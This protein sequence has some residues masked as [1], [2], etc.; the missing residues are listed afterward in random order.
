MIF[1]VTEI[2]HPVVSGGRRYALK[3]ALHAYSQRT[4]RGILTILPPPAS[5]PARSS[6]DG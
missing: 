3:P 4:I 1:R 5:V 6:G 2:S